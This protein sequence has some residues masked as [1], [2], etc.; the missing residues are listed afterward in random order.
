M[1]PIETQE[2]LGKLKIKSQQFV[3]SGKLMSRK[4]FSR[5]LRVTI[6]STQAFFPAFVILLKGH[7]Y[8]GFCV[9][10]QAL[11]TRLDSHH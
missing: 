1:E 10:W 11:N 4:M 7:S 5:Q 9:G 3:T 2:Y 8:T 6:L